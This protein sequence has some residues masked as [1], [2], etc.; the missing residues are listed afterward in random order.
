MRGYVQW[1]PVFCSFRLNTKN[2]GAP[3]K[4][5]HFQVLWH[6]YSINDLKE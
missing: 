4:L 3:G 1:K 6:K 2:F 5:I